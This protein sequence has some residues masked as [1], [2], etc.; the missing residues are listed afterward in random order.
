MTDPIENDDLDL[1]LELANAQ[2]QA[3]LRSKEIMKPCPH[4]EALPIIESKDAYGYPR[5]TSLK[6]E[7]VCLDYVAD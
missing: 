6:H 1:A 3:M 4:C 5:A 2:H 7:E